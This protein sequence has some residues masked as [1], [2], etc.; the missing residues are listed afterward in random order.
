MVI[1]VGAL[2]VCG[3]LL[4][5]FLLHGGPRERPQVALT[6]EAKQYVRHLELSGVEMKAT[7]NMLGNVLVEIVGTITNKGERPLRLV[8]ILCIFYDPWAKE[9][10]RERVAIVRS[11]GASLKKGE[12][13]PFRLPFDNLPA[14]WNQSMPQMVIASV[15]FDD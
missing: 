5:Y 13:R 2:I 8:E 15:V 9:V 3:A 7:E 11:G 14:N 10:H 1:V 6:P 4:Y 12:S